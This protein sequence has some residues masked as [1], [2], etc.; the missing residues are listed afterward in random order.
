M[1]RC[2]LKFGRSSIHVTLVPYIDT[3]TEMTIQMFG[4]HAVWPHYDACSWLW[5]KRHRQAC[6]M[7][8]PIWCSAISIV[9]GWVS[10]WKAHNKLCPISL[11]NTMVETRYCNI[12]KQPPEDTCWNLLK[13]A[14]TKFK[15]CIHTNYY[16]SLLR[17][18]R[19]TAINAW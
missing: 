2:L 3:V 17:P 16:A 6:A 1:R 9:V 11:R 4:K 19:P 12:Q 14:L 13:K 8:A 7:S 10:Q 18:K 5:I 15:K